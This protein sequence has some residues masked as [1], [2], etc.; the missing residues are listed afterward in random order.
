MGKRGGGAKRAANTPSKFQKTISLRE[1]ASGRKQTKGGSTNVKAILKNEH[2][3][4][5]AVWAS[6][7]ASI[8]SLASF[9]GHQ[10]AADG[11]ASSIPPDSSFFPCQRFLFLSFPFSFKESNLFVFSGTE[12]YMCFRNFRIQLLEVNKICL[13]CSGL[14]FP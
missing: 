1:E 10:L 5:L 13:R 3:Q 9:F 4:N 7:E 12:L 8:P 11:E 6:G 14:H 2:L